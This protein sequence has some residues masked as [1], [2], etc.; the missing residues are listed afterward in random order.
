VEIALASNP[1]LI[2]IQQQAR[3]ARFDVASLRADR[4]PTLDAVSSGRYLNALGRA[5]EVA[6]VPEGTLQNS[7]T[8]VGVGVQLRLPIY[9]GGVVAGRVRQA[10]AIQA[11]IVEQGIAVERRVVADTRA[12][13]ASYQA[14]LEAIRSQEIA[15]AANSLA[16]EGTRAEQAIGTRNVLDVLN[17]E[18]ELLNSQVAL[19]SA[20]RD[21]YV[22]GFNLLKAMGQAEAKDL[23]LDVG[24][25][26]YDPDVNYRLAV[27]RSSDWGDSAAPKPVATRTVTL[28]PAHLNGPL[29]LKG[30]T[31]APAASSPEVARV[32]D[33]SKGGRLALAPEAAEPQTSAAETG[34]RHSEPAITPAVAAG[35]A[36]PTRLFREDAPMLSDAP[37]ASGQS[38]ASL[39]KASAAPAEQ[40][41]R[42][43]DHVAAVQSRE[44]GAP[45]AAKSPVAP[46]E[47]GRVP[48]SAEDKEIR[49][50]V[51]KLGPFRTA[52][53]VER[54]RAQ[55]Q[56]LHGLLG[57]EPLS[58]TVTT[59][60]RGTFHRLAV[61]GFRDPA[62]AK[63]VCS[64]IRAKRWSC[65]VRSQ[66]N[67]SKRGILA[68]IFHYLFN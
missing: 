26:L 63:R 20:R 41:T 44:T 22:A 27:R 21:A 19:V 67:S 65:F 10:Q 15:V 50:Y 24:G 4:L 42:G 62:E 5:D 57:T 48:P 55:V 6:G 30:S 13:F 31:V 39:Q 17:A 59:N 52:A 49:R 18:Q 60:R 3:A 53:Q 16:L 40:M 61:A 64:S 35:P 56:R 45:A 32:A 66:T 29:E 43:G 14:A 9:Q 58:T 28:S 25:P 54:A 1:D 38:L 46:S 34:P 33:S 23:A 8:A 2:A 36:S 11:Q 37:S 12:S 68:A 7:T 51:A 47:A